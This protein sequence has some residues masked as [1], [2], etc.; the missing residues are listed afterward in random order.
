MTWRML[1]PLAGLVLVLAAAACAG[2]NDGGGVA[3]AGTP[4]VA[5]SSGG[6]AS[7]LSQQEKALKFAQCMREHGVPMNDPDPNGGMGL[8]LGGPGV[9]P[10]K[11]QAAQQAC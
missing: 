11:I 8:Q 9:D 4:G 5:R 1:R 3:T 7:G 10:A 6:A 2:S